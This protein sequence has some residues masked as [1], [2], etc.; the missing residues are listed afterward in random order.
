MG[1]NFEDV[2]EQFQQAKAQGKG[3]DGNDWCN[4]NWNAIRAIP[5]SVP[6]HVLEAFPG[7]ML[8]PA[9]EVQN[10]THWPW[11][12]GCVLTLAQEAADTFEQLPIEMINVPVDFEVRGKA[13]FKMQVPL[14]VHDHAVASDTVQE[15]KI[16][17][18]G[19][20]G[21][22]FGEVITLKLKV[23]KPSDESAAVEVY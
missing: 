1:I 6:E 21:H 9:I 20:G 14:K 4:K 3:K 12:Y 16:A 17:F 22:Q 7:Q 19:P 8:L 23:I 2:K 11:K 10:G 5:M 13:T 15:I 18:R